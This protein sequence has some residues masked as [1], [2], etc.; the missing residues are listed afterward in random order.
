MK[1]KRISDVGQWSNIIEIYHLQRNSKMMGCGS[2]EK[3]HRT[4]VNRQVWSKS[5]MMRQILKSCLPAEE[6][7]NGGRWWRVKCCWNWSSSWKLKNDFIW[8]K[9][10]SRLEVGQWWNVVEIDHYEK[11]SEIIW[12]W[13]GEKDM[14]RWWVIKYCGN[15]S[16]WDK[17]Y[18]DLVLRKRKRTSH[19][20]K[21]SNIVEN[22]D[23][24]WNSKVVSFWWR[25]RKHRTLVNCE[26]LLENSVMSFI[27]YFCGVVDW[28][29]FCV[30]CFGWLFVIESGFCRFTEDEMLVVVSASRVF[31]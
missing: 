21:W 29:G 11:N 20:G 31:L 3:E 19:I 15:S 16:W 25:E 22:D 30:L 12:F 9:G 27:R 13:W 17:F 6:K 2:R 26:I 23:G 4:L 24:E 18:N 10:K 28:L 8:M 7:K 5:I 1:R 14:G